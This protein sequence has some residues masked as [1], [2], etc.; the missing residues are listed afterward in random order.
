MGSPIEIEFA[1]NFN[2][3]SILPPTFAILQIRPLVP[4]HEQS[5]ITWDNNIDRE[6]V[7]IHSDKALGNGVIKSIKNIVFIPP[8]TFDS[9]KTIDIAEEIGKITEKL[10][11]EK[12]PYIL[13][14]PG[15][16]GTEDRF[17][18]IPVKWNQIAGVKVMVETALENF[19]IDPSQGTHFFHNI[20]SRG[21]GYINVPYNSQEN[22]ID[23]KWLEEKKSVKKLRYVKHIELSSPLNIKLDGR[24]GSALI[25]KSNKS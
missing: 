25:I 8:K 4:S 22:F 10:R 16:W 3:N 18:G 13:V 9:I 15:R 5:E 17:L 6:T 7:F 21:I 14:G 11:L 19:N 24:H 12:Q 23:W 1:V 2:E 20:T